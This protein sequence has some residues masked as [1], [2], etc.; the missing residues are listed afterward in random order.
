MGFSINLVN[1]HQK[2]FK[3]GGYEGQNL[4]VI[5]KETFVIFGYCLEPYY[6][7]FK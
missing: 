2:S 7:I 6:L 4:E 3:I 1:L 5:R